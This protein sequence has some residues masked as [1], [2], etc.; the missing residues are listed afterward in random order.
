MVAFT[1]SVIDAWK[2]SGYKFIHILAKEKYGV[3]RPLY[4]EV[5]VTNGFVIPMAEIGLLQ[6]KDDYFLVKEKNAFH[7]VLINRSASSLN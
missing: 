6:L 4:H 3:L 7:P 1:T 5:D 2:S